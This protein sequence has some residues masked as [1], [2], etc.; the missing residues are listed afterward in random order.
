MNS[1]TTGYTT[2]AAKMSTHSAMSHFGDSRNKLAMHA[3]DTQ[4]LTIKLKIRP[5]FTRAN[6]PPDAYLN[7]RCVLRTTTWY[8]TP[9]VEA[10]VKNAQNNAKN[11][12][13]IFVTAKLSK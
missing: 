3:A 12:A 5:L 13:G 11:G 4:K 7:W 9:A 1:N 6:R 2:T 10:R 8:T